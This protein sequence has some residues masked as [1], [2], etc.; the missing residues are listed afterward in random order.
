MGPI[1]NFTERE[2]FKEADGKLSYDEIYWGFISE[3]AARM[4]DNKEKYGRHNYRNRLYRKEELLDAALRHLIKVI[5]PDPQD[6]ETVHQHLASVSCNM[7]MY[8]YQI[9]NFS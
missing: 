6:K 1:E 4:E 5:E 8:M 3:M 9:K 2:G 7:M